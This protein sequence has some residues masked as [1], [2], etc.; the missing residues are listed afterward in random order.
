MRTYG[1][2]CPIARASEILAERWTPIILRNMLLG[3]STFTEIA[4]GAP[5]LSHT[6]L[7]AR[8]REL[9]RAGVVERTRGPSARGWRY[10]PTDAGRDLAGVMAALG[11]WGERWMELAPEHL[12]PGV[13]LH[14]WCSWY[15]DRPR[16][17]PKRVVAKFDFPDLPRKGGLLWMI[18]DGDRSEVCQHDPG[19]EVD[20]YVQAESRALAEWHLGRLEWDE[21]LRTARIQV[22]GVRELARALPTWNRRSAAARAGSGKRPA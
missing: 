13:V 5:G 17:P 3:S 9:E 6:L 21:A 8:L 15:L 12:D 4:D 10:V 14:A 7:T 11:T 19:F 2:Y 18:F 1:Q 16:L 22:S 20:L